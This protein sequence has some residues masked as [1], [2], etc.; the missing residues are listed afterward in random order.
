[1]KNAIKIQ[2]A[3][4]SER[5]NKCELRKWIHTTI[6]DSNNKN[7]VVTSKFRKMVLPIFLLVTIGDP[8]EK[9]PNE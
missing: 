5:E 2:N 8:I 6:P 4:T 9:E 1:V 3:N 7:S